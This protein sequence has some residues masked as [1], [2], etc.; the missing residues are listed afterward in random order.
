MEGIRETPFLATLAEWIARKVTRQVTKVDRLISK[1]M[2]R[3][4][5]NALGTARST[6]SR[7]FLIRP[8]LRQRF[9]GAADFSRQ[10]FQ[11]SL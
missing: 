4:N 10:S 3:P 7:R 5:R 11:K 8:L 1:P 2:A 6:F 9:A